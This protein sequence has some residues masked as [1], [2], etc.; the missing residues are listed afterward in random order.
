MPYSEKKER[1]NVPVKLRAGV[2]KI[3]QVQVITG[4]QRKKVVQN[5]INNIGLNTI[6]EGMTTVTLQIKMY[7]Q[8]LFDKIGFSGSLEGIVHILHRIQLHFHLQKIYYE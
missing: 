4:L 1:K 3:L 8:N 2:G 7:L 5:S 6:F